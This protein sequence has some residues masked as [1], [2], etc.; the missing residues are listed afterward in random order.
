LAAQSALRTQDG[1]SIEYFGCA[2]HLYRQL[3]IVY[4]Q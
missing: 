3:N 4:T 2:S 1:N